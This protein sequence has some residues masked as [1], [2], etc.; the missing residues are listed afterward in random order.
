MLYH[1]MSFEVFRK[2]YQFI[3]NNV[4]QNIELSSLT[5]YH[6]VSVYWK[7]LFNSRQKSVNISIM[8]KIHSSTNQY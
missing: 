5:I 6:T 3:D 4:N 8:V 2:E 7:K 1:Q